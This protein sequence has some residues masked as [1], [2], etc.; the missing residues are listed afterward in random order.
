MN[1]RIIRFVSYDGSSALKAF[2]D[3]VLDEAIVIKGVRVVEGRHGAFVSMPR[4]QGKDGTWYDSIVPLTKE[5][6]ALLSCAALDA[7]H[8]SHA[9][10]S[11]AVGN[12]Q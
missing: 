1:V 4:Q 3:V 8:A 7:Y 6:K 10:G 9:N 12:R 2:C 11:S 5:M